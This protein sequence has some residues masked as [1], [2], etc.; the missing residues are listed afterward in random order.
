[1]AIDGLVEEPRTLAIDD[2]IA[3]MP[4]EERVYRHRCVEAWSMVVPWSGFPL[5]ALVDFAKPLSTAKYV[6][7]ETFLDP[8]MASGQRAFG[9]PWPYTEGLTIAEASH[10]LAF[11]ATGVY[12]KPLKKKFGSQL[13]LAVPWKDGFK[14]IK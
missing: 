2:L 12:G 14:S 4:L 6:R 9:Y 11:M 7:M 10:D 1:M 8:D 13:R 5:R 3:Q